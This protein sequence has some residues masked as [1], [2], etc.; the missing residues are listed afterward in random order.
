MKSAVR[1]NGYE[2]YAYSHKI[3]VA[4]VDAIGEYCPPTSPG[5]LSPFSRSREL[6]LIY[7][8]PVRVLQLKGHYALVQSFLH[9]SFLKEKWSPFC[10]WVESSA[11]LDLQDARV[12]EN[13]GVITRPWSPLYRAKE[14]AKLEILAYLPW[15]SI[16]QLCSQDGEYYKITQGRYAGALVKVRDVEQFEDVDEETLR[17]YFICC[18]QKF[19]GQN[20]V[21][22]GNVP[23]WDGVQE[24]SLYKEK[25]LG[26]NLGVDC[27]GLIYSIWLRF[28]LSVP[29][30]SKDQAR[31]LE[32]VALKEL[33]RGDLLFWSSSKGFDQIDHVSVIEDFQTIIEAKE[34]LGRVV[35][36][37]I[38]EATGLG[39]SELNSGW[40]EIAES[41][42]VLC[43]SISPWIRMWQNI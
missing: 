20:Y 4:V 16:V 33:K 37:S 27:S 11:L 36:R 14:E 41:R 26:V 31:S 18:C 42:F 23:Q 25:N 22:G 21:W 39:I 38:R 12:S 40:T 5:L 43:M 3:D 13:I 28:G 9:R 2:D 34:S 24:Q 17:W 19:L 7:G 32:Q 30:D 35:R 6:Q 15:G 29:R 8:Q 1:R 10:V